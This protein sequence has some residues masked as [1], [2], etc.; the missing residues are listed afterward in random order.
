MKSRTSEPFGVNL[1]ADA[2]DAPARCDLL[3][4]H[5]VKVASFALAPKKELIVKLKDHGI[6]VMPSVGAPGTPRRL[7]PGAPTR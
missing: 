5:G 7:R 2:A 6:V 1:R 4:K 3:I